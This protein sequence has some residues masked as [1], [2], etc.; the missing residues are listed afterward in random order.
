[1]TA[2]DE[3]DLRD[4][5]LERHSDLTST[6]RPTPVHQPLTM[7][8]ETRSGTLTRQALLAI[9]RSAGNRAAVTLMRD[10]DDAPTSTSELAQGSGSQV[11]N[12]NPASLRP[13]PAGSHS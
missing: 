3:A 7:G 10:E 13:T 1:M 5:R 12:T 8:C 6:V 9:Q 4:G 11:S 2:H